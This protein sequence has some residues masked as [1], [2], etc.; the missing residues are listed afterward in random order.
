MND[1]SHAG[2]Q[3]GFRE[4]CDHISAV[5]DAAQFERMRWA[6]DIGPRLAEMVALMLA[7]V[8]DRIDLEFSEEQ[9]TTDIKRYILKVHGTRVIGLTL[10]IEDGQAHLL[11]IEIE[12]SRYR[13][14]GKGTLSVELEALNAGWMALALRTAFG[15]IERREEPRAVAPAAVEPA[16]QTSQARPQAQR[17]G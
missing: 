6:R 15:L 7:S 16:K 12:R 3:D 4:M 5:V 17:A 13:L 9:S 8:E 2:F 1:L 11:P 14:S 10:W